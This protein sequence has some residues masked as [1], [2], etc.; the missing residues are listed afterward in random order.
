VAYLLL[1]KRVRQRVE[2]LRFML[3][4][5][6]VGALTVSA[7][8]PFVDQSLGSLQGADWLWVTLLALGPGIGGHGLLAW[9]HPRVD[10]SV[11]SLLIQGEPVA[12]SVAAWAFLGEEVGLVQGLA[13]AVVLAALGV[14]A[15]TE[16][17]DV[18]L[19][20]DEAVS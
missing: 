1:S 7:M 15:Y 13:M 6:V 18:G 20:L 12:A 14:L 5:S 16:A 3:V 17:R 19:A 11:S 9:A 4:M 2:T 8:V 10:A